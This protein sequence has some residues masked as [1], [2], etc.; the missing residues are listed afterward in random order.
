MV[1]S[2]LDL[3]SPTVLTR[4]PV[5]REYFAPGQFHRRHRAAHVVAEPYYRRPNQ[6]STRCDY[7]SRPGLKDLRLSLVH[8]N[9]GSPEVTDIKR[10]IVLV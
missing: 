7:S 6:R 5:A 10:R 1:D 9:V 2:Q 8:E 3:S 4:M